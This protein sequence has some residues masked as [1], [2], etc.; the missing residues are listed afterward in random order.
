[1]AY[2]AG[3][4]DV[5][6]VHGRA[7]IRA[8][9]ELMNIAMAA[10]T[11]RRFLK[12][13]CTR[14]GVNAFAIGFHARSVAGFTLNRLQLRLMRYL[15][16]VGVTGCAVERTVNGFPPRLWFDLQRNFFAIP[17]FFQPRCAVT[18]ETSIFSYRLCAQGRAVQ[19][20]ENG[21][22]EKT[23]PLS[24]IASHRETIQLN[25][26]GSSKPVLCLRCTCWSCD[27]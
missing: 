16:N 13:L 10:C 14:L 8:R 27:C 9:N 18:A 15:R 6:W 12:P 25:D 11:S 5:F 21:D 2:G 23:E 19:K 1:M 24:G 22:K 20:S 3:L 7:R 26:L 17:K 4:S